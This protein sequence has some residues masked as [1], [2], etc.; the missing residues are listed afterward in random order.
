MST[1]NICFYKENQE[2]KKKKACK[3]IAEA[4]VD[5]SSAELFSFFLSVFIVQVDIYFIYHMVFK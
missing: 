2:K 4:S 5:K 1:H 3:N